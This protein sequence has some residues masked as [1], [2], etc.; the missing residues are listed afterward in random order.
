MSNRPSR[1]SVRVTDPR[2]LKA[3][4]H[5]LRLRLLGSLRLHGPSTA[6]LLGQRLSESSGAT[7]YH[8]RELERFGFVEDA[9][10]RGTG[11]ERWWQAS[12]RSTSYNRTD[13]GGTGAAVADELQR[14]IVEVRGRVLGSWLEQRGGLSAQWQE[15]ADFNDL[16]LHLTPEQGRRLGAELA[17]VLTRWRD[18]EGAEPG[19]PGTMIVT[20]FADVV[21][22]PEYPL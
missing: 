20:A 12:H 6:T 14:R 9:P 2:T 4:A 7:S 10:D 15:V 1:P 16:P 21:A 11:R 3:L 13:F 5:P 8:L 22:L 19:T 17:A 18:E